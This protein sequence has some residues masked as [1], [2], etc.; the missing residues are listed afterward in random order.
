M[1]I[2]INGKTLFN[3]GEHDLNDLVN[4][5]DYREN[6][7]LEYKE[8]LPFIFMN[9]ADGNEKKRKDAI[10]EFRRDVC[11]FANAQ[12]GYLLY[13]ISEE[14]GCAKEI[15]GI[16]LPA[17]NTDQFERECNAKLQLIFPRSP[18]VQFHFVPLQSGKYVVVL[19]VHHDS[20]APYTHCEEDRNYQFYKRV[21]NEKQIMSYAEIKSGFINSLSLEKE[22]R[23]YRMEQIHYR[24]EKTCGDKFLLLHFIPETFIDSSYNIK[25]FLMQWNHTVDFRDV[26]YS[27]SC[28][29][30]YSANVD[31]L[32][33]QPS[34]EYN[35]YYEGAVKNNG[36]IDCFCLLCEEP[37]EHKNK[38]GKIWID[39]QSLWN[40]IDAVYKSYVHH[41]KNVLPNRKIYI[42]LSLVNVQDIIVYDADNITER[43]MDRNAIMTNP[44]CLSDFNDDN[45]VDRTN[46]NLYVDFLLSLGVTKDKKLLEILDA[47][48][49]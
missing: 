38:I 36:C 14:K 27:W 44:V 20:F 33:F 15:K 28:G 16:D 22:I 6:D 32:R 39:W 4:N 24:Q 34:L 30:R 11:S 17:N 29:C 21:G 8:T 2:K 42:C 7:F 49:E 25:P 19:Y 43:H 41:M 5:L 3:I 40:K 47:D 18:F 45:D 23:N 10:A 46:K 31:G 48:M 35:Q 12:G 26:F 37:F 13:G 9:K 1:Q